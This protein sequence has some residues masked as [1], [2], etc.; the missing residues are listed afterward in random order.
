MFRL[1]PFRAFGSGV[2]LWDPKDE[3]HFVEANSKPEAMC[4]IYTELLEI[5]EKHKD[6]IDIDRLRILRNGK[7]KCGMIGHNWIY[8]SRTG[9]PLH[10]VPICNKEDIVP[11]NLYQPTEY[12]IKMTY[13]EFT[14][15]YILDS[16]KGQLFKDDNR[17]G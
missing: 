12:N 10:L 11:E 2:Y 8:N 4:I 6:E 16:L 9:L 3:I 1:E 14:G 7:L 13:H 5:G 17:T 15:Q